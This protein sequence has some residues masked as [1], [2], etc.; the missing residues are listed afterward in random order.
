VRRRLLEVAARLFAQ[1][2]SQG[3]GLREIARTADVTPGMISYYFGDKQGLLSAV[4]G[5]VFERLFKGFQE[6]ASTPPGDL[7]L[8]EAFVRLYVGVIGR[9]PWVVPLIVREVL[10]HDGPIRA[11]FVEQFATRA[12]QLVRPL[13]AREI[14]AGRLREDLDPVL[15]VLSLLGMCVFPFLAHPVTGP[16]FGYELDD[17][18]AQRLMSHTARL[19]LDGARARTA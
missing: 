10:A 1:R 3:V 17:A 13:F 8:P 14:Q 16:A 6:L 4:L 12:A 15:A 7:P 9:E 5:D 11:V 2:G 19:Y 18:F